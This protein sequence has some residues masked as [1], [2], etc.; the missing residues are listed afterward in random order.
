MQAQVLQQ[1][2]PLTENIHYSTTSVYVVTSLKHNYTCTACR[3]T[4]K[5]WLNCKLCV[6]WFICSQAKL[7]A[8]R[9]NQRAGI[10]VQAEYLNKLLTTR[11]IFI[12]QQVAHV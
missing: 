11:G 9:C 5:C 8:A 6:Q 10:F 3:V 12:T 7:F 1:S 4:S 2:T